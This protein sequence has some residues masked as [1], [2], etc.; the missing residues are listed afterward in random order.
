MCPFFSWRKEMK[1]TKRQLKQLIREEKQKLTEGKVGQV[2]YECMDALQAM[3][4]EEPFHVCCLCASKAIEQCGMG[5]ADM[6]TCCNLIQD[7]IDDGLLMAVPHP[8]C[9][10]VTV[11]V[12]I[13]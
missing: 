3:A 1:I 5:P 7:C 11:Y 2:W 4:M 9:P 12:A 13:D 10:S 8:D 6:S